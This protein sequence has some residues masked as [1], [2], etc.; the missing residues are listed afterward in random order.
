[1]EQQS[2]HPLAAAIVK[3]AEER[4]LALLKVESFAS[5]TGKGVKGIVSGHSVALGNQ[6]LVDELGL[7]IEGPAAR[8]E[9]DRRDGQTVMFVVIDGKAAGLLGV[10]DPIKETTPEAVQQL[11]QDGIKI[12][13]LTGDSRTTAEAVA[14]RLGLDEVVAEVLPNQKAEIVKRF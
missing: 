10:A 1:L 5:L 4:G 3:G 2:E 9:E 7:N 12:V 14:R 6:A 13:M 11:H 8:G